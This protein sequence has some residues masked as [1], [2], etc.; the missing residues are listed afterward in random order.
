MGL[1]RL[2][3]QPVSRLQLFVARLVEPR[4]RKMPFLLLAIYLRVTRWALWAGFF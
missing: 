2:E 3:H 1:V 4:S